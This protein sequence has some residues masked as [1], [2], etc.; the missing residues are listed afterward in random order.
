MPVNKIHI[1]KS[2]FA[3]LK[4]TRSL[5][6]IILAFTQY[7]CRY[8]IIGNGT[9]SFY[10]ISTDWKFFLLVVCTVFVAAAGYIIND[11]YDVKIDL[12]NKPK[13][14][15]IGKVLHRR[16]A[17]VSHFILNTLACFLAIFLGW[18]I[19]AIIV[20]TTIL[21]WLYA[22]EL[23]RTALIGNL[24]ISVLTG[25]S[26]Y[27]PVFLYGTAKQTL[28]LYALFAFF[29]S[30]VREIIKDMEDIKGDEEFGCKTLPIIWGIRKTKNVIY[31]I[32]LL[33]IGI[34]SII[35]I[36]AQLNTQLYFLIFPAPLF[37]W[38]LIKLSK[39]DTSAQFLQLSFLCKW[40]MVA[41]VISMVLL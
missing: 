15:V 12:I 5:N 22:N 2:L 31:L 23:K 37:I 19:F 27:M 29:I 34:I 17:L 28:L 25:L 16:V 38:L 36:Q 7:M 40:I 14:V 21:M 33:F 13:R 18:K 4:L 20:A 32:S 6:L 11:Y 8:F 3:F 39:A 1:K 35:L 10:E 30:L 41:G 26:V 24:L 9:P